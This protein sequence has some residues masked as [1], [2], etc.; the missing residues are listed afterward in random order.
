MSKKLYVGNL[1]FN[2]TDDDLREVFEKHGTVESAKVIADAHL[3]LMLRV[4]QQR[5]AA[6]GFE[7]ADELER[8]SGQ[9]DVYGT[10]RPDTWRGG[11]AVELKLKGFA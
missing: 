5:V 11:G 1:P 9:V 3:K 8:S 6:F 7:M 10:L 4:G 2:T